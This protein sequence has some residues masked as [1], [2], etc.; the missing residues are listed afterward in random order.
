LLP[1]RALNEIDLMKFAEDIPYFRGVF[2]RDTLPLKPHRN[3]CGIVN[4]DLSTGV[5]TH[6]ISYY[7]HGTDIICFNSFGNL[8][9]PKELITYLGSNIKYNYESYQNYNTVICGHLCL[10]F[11]YTLS[12]MN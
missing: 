7:K 5:G 2:M 8:Q 4:L 6:W 12:N 10:I 1:K 3:E 9:P 11:L